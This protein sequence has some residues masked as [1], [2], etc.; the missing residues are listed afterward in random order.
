[1]PRKLIA[2]FTTESDLC[3][4]ARIY[5]EGDAFTVLT[6]MGRQQTGEETCAERVQALRAGA[7]WVWPALVLLDAEAALLRFAAQH[8]RGWGARLRANW[9]SARL[10]GADG[11][12]LHALRNNYGPEV[13]AQAA[14]AFAA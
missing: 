3:R 14:A 7:R 1:M 2:T 5:Q 9:M 12:T 11:A 8:G 10:E 13:L 4:R 6:F